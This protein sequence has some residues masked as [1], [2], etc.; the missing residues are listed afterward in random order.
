MPVPKQVFS[1][2][3]P[4]SVIELTQELIGIPSP[5]G[6][7]G[8]IAR[9]IHDRMV[10][11]CHDAKMVSAE[12]DRPNLLCRYN[13]STRGK[14]L[15]LVGHMDT[16]DL[17]D[18]EK[19]KWTVD[20]YGGVVKNNKIYGLGASDMKGSLAAMMIAI[21]S[22]SELDIELLNDVV[23]IFCV[24]EEKGS[25]KGMQHL[26]DR[27]LIDPNGAIA[28][29]GEPTNMKVQGWFKGWAE[30]EITT[31]GR[32]THSSKFEEGINA[33]HGM[34]DV[35]HSLR[36]YELKHKEHPFLGRSTLS[37]GT[38]DG[39]V[40]PK[41]VPDYCKSAIEVRM[42][43]NQGA[44]NVLNEIEVLLENL[45]ERDPQ[46][47]AEIKLIRAKDPAEIPIDSPIIELTREAAQ[48][49]M[50]KP[51]EYGRE[52]IGGGDV[53]LLIRYLGIPSILFG[54]GLLEHSHTPD[55]FVPIKNVV[56]TAK[57]YASLILKYCGYQE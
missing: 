8:N 22:I 7:E 32:T 28:V 38:I 51:P 49:I 36:E 57:I 39:G 52:P 23:L 13:V 35:L 18:Q 25:R 17:V 6:Q 27:K 50:G 19:E 14:S 55:E 29:E 24:D 40:N 30:Y 46:L 10:E 5:V 34:V 20:P 47:S 1:K 45:R 42:V 37:I 12:R 15:V 2:I 56:D 31:R 9:F 26:I 3:Q 11:I 21:G 41:I 33:I 43:P 16:I 4:P 48:E 44:K 53:N 54:P